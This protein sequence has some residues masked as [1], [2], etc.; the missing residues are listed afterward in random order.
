M[1]APFRL[2]QPLPITRQTDGRF[3]EVT[4]QDRLP[5][6]PAEVSADGGRPDRW[7]PGVGQGTAP[8]RGPEHPWPAVAKPRPMKLGG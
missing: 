5:P 8:V 1:A 3:R 7:A 4:R 2:D 6:N